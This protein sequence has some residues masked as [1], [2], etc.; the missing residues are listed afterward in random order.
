MRGVRRI[1]D[2][3]TRLMM[4]AASRMVMA[5]R[6]NAP[7]KSL[8]PFIASSEVCTR[9]GTPRRDVEVDQAALEPYPA[10]H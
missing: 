5:V 3:E 7:T 2:A 8:Y 4:P 1:A 10:F 9:R 6:S